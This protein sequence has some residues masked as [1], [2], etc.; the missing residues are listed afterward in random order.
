MEKVQLGGVI[1]LSPR[2]GG[3]ELRRGNVQFLSGVAGDKNEE[4]GEGGWVG[5][6]GGGGVGGVAERSWGLPSADRFEIERNGDL[7]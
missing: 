7:G 4:R 6:G 1:H 3:G 2:G 5:G